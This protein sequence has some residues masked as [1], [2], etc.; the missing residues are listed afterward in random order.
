[1]TQYVTHQVFQKLHEE[2]SQVAQE[3]TEISVQA[4]EALRQATADYRSSTEQMKKLHKKEIS[5]RDSVIR[6]LICALLAVTGCSIYLGT[7]I[8]LN[9]C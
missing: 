5:E 7:R 9:K 4:T 1:M 2:H 3:A 8:I 6:G